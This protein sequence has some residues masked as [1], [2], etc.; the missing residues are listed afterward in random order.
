MEVMER[1]DNTSSTGLEVNL[2]TAVTWLVAHPRSQ[3]S[4]FC[5]SLN[6]FLSFNLVYISNS[7]NVS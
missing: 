6:V 4:I 3:L 5:I 2:T 7:I 1:R